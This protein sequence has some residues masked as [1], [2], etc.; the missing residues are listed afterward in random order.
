MIMFY[1]CL[2]SIHA[3]QILLQTSEL[4]GKSMADCKFTLHICTE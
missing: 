2:T 3:S 1:F 4:M